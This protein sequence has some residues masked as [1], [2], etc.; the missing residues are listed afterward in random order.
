MP[1]YVPVSLAYNAIITK[2]ALDHIEAGISAA[3]PQIET[4]AA[5]ALKAPLASPSFT[6][7][8][9]GITKAMVGLGNV[10]NTSDA[11]KP[12]STAVQS[13]LSGKA[14]LDSPA[15][16]GTPTV[17]GAPIGSGGST[18]TTGY[19][20]SQIDNLLLAK[21]PLQSP[22]FTG[23]V[24][25]ITTTMLP[26][27]TTAVDNRINAKVAS[28]GTGGSGASITYDATSGVITGTTGFTYDATTGLVS[29]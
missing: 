20:K 17:N 24:S 12:I 28:G 11:N 27:F 4:T 7:T 16:T 8:V 15:F 6:G 10:D 29:I 23:T 22:T 13:A 26:D 2:A 9:S 3:A 25:G 18:T 1:A 19:T 5:L 21:A 14:P